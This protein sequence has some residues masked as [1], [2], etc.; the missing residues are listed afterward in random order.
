M[1]YGSECILVKVFITIPVEVLN[2]LKNENF[3]A[4]QIYFQ[5]TWPTDLKDTNKNSLSN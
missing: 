5:Q 2:N 1:F 3:H 4:N